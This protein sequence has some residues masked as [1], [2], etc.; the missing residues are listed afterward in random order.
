MVAMMTMKY[1]FEIEMGSF[2]DLPK[3]VVWMIFSRCIEQNVVYASFGFSLK[4]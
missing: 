4:A 1:F 3:D 2:N